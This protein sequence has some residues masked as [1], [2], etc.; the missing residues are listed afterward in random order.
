M[1]HFI[2][3]D[4]AVTGFCVDDRCVDCL[5]K[6]TLY[7]A[8]KNTKEIVY[9]KEIFEKD[10]LARNLAADEGRIY[11]GDFCTLYVLNRDDYEII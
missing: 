4:G 6:K 5:C 8:D 11:I 3:L 7:K 10:G 1:E 2:K 9:K